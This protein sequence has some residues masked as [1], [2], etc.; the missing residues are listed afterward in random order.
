[1]GE[2]NHSALNLKIF[3]YYEYEKKTNRLNIC[4][5]KNWFI[6]GESLDMFT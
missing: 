3:I 6:V 5:T 4:M 2:R 1:M